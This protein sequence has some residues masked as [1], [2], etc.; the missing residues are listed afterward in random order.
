MLLNTEKYSEKLKN[1]HR[2]M[3]HHHSSLLGSYCKCDM[4]YGNQAQLDD[5]NRESKNL[6]LRFQAGFHFY[7][8]VEASNWP[9]CLTAWIDGSLQKW[10]SFCKVLPSRCM[11]SGAQPDRPSDYWS[12]LTMALFL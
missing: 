5:S 9:L 2:I 12:P 8:G 4:S 3:L 11:N 6:I 10:L 1:T 7:Y